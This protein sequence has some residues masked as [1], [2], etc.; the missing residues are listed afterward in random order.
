MAENRALLW[1]NIHMCRSK[2]YGPNKSKFLN[3]SQSYINI[4]TH[5][6]SPATEGCAIGVVWSGF[7][8]PCL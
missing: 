6:R 2:A 1:Q 7:T 4:I 8:K 3:Q 5:C